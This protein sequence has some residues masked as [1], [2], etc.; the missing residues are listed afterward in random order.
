[1]EVTAQ[2]DIAAS[3]LFIARPPTSKRREMFSGFDAM[4]HT[5]LFLSLIRR[6]EN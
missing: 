2:A 1:M 3:T 6:Q 5:P 4:P